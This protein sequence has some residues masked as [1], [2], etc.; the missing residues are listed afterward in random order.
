[1]DKFYKNFQIARI[2]LWLLVAVFVVLRI[3]VAEIFTAFAVVTGA[4]A[5]IMLGIHQIFKYVD[6][7][8]SI[9]SGFDTYLADNLR[10]GFITK[11]QFDDRDPAL[12][13]DYKRLYKG[14]KWARILGFVACFAVAVFLVIWIVR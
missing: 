7:K 11:Q 6:L 13:K 14:E 9:E 4:I 3:F 2:I 10:D 1:M 8:H 12:Y 5:F